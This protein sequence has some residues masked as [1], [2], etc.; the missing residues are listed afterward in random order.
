MS[1]KKIIGFGGILLSYAGAVFGTAHTA[2]PA[3]F[4]AGDRM[5]RYDSRAAPPSMDFAGFDFSCD[6][7]GV[8]FSGRSGGSAIFAGA[9]DINFY[10]ARTGS[11]YFG[12]RAE[13]MFG[14]SNSKDLLMLTNGKLGGKTYRAG[15]GGRFGYVF[16][17]DYSGPDSRMGYD[18]P[19]TLLIIPFLSA[20]FVQTKAEN[21]KGDDAKGGYLI[22]LNQPKLGAGLLT[23]IPTGNLM[24]TISLTVSGNVFSNSGVTFKYGGNSDPL[25]NSTDFDDAS[26]T[27]IID[28]L[29]IRPTVEL[30]MIVGAP[31]ETGGF[32][33]LKVLMKYTTFKSSKFKDTDSAGTKISVDANVKRDPAPALLEG[34]IGLV[35]GYDIH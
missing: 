11:F 1:I 31:S 13:G 24:G 27:T 12:V 30:E 17:V 7:G 22:D 9:T 28:T 34:F 6:M 8:K 25:A 29:M 35:L 26:K 3:A 4:V 14:K 15:I 5:S 20:N 19:V 32:L 21:E 10:Y 33:G 2:D 23:I 16:V 18:S